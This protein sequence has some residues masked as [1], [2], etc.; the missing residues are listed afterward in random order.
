MDFELLGVVNAATFP[1]VHLK[2][3]NLNK[4]IQISPV[5]PSYLQTNGCLFLQ[6]CEPHTCSNE[7]EGADQINNG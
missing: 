1:A 5:I 7:S 6:S 3:Q 2:V 4:Q